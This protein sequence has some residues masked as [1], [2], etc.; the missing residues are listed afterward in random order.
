MKKTVCV[1][2]VF[3][4][5][6]SLMVRAQ[7][8]AL[9]VKP[10]IRYSDREWRTIYETPRDKRLAGNYI[11]LLLDC[12]EETLTPGSDYKAIK[13]FRSLANEYF[14]H[15]QGLA[16]LTAAGRPLPPPSEQ[17]MELV[18][19]LA[20]RKMIDRPQASQLHNIFI[21]SLAEP[22]KGSGESF[23][24]SDKL[25][26]LREFME[27]Q[28]DILL[29]QTVAPDIYLVVYDEL[30]ARSS[31]MVR[32]KMLIV[33]ERALS[34]RD[35][36][37]PRTVA[38]TLKGKTALPV[39]AMP[40]AQ[41]LSAEPVNTIVELKLLESKNQAVVYWAVRVMTLFDHEAVWAMTDEILGKR[42]GDASLRGAMAVGL[43]NNAN[44]AQAARVLAALVD[45]LCQESL[46]AQDPLERSNLLS[47]VFDVASCLRPLATPETLGEVNAAQF[48]ETYKKSLKSGT[49]DLARFNDAVQR[50]A[51]FFKK[52]E[53]SSK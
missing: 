24:P 52:P 5:L 19:Y 45:R 49:V 43:T 9:V 8:A 36:R 10:I 6:V 16:P 32:M 26:D 21:K 38:S 51:G 34:W 33:M 46:K 41:P 37:P 14:L 50:L 17:V 44:P 7:G 25:T 15:M 48:E 3:G 29:A 13:S 23:F 4:F 47:E 20:D 27:A 2:F 22:E 39:G 35:G 1:L 18:P 28:L 30:K 42:F 40:G 31:D 12:L 11:R 53:V